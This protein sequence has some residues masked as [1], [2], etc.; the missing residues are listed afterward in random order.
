M[1]TA[2]PGDRAWGASTSVLTC[3]GAVEARRFRGA[4]AA[5][6]CGKK[7]VHKIASGGETRG[8]G[9]AEEQEWGVRVS[10]T[11]RGG[12]RPAPRTRISRAVAWGGG[13]RGSRRATPLSEGLGLGEGT[14]SGRGI[15]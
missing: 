9:A 12:S 14:H 13:G 11:A 1:P 2:P 7:F 6:A 5:P 10:P 4:G 15:C 3:A 8:E